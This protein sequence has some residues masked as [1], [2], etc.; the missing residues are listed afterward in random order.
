MAGTSAPSTKTFLETCH[1]ATPRVA[2]TRLRMLC[3]QTNETLR[4]EIV[5]IT[6][7][8]ARNTNT[9]RCVR[10]LKQFDATLNAR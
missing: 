3:R 10:E 2:V 1:V 4:E 7:T 8:E 9:C 5:R 6:G